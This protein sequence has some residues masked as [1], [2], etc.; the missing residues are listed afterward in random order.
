M[1]LDLKR[2]CENDPS[3]PAAAGVHA[4][5]ANELAATRTALADLKPAAKTER[6]DRSHRWAT[7]SRHR[8]TM[9]QHVA[10]AEWEESCQQL[11]GTN[12]ALDL[13]EWCLLLVNQAADALAAVSVESP[14]SADKHCDVSSHYGGDVDELAMEDLS[15]L[16]ELLLAVLADEFVAVH[17]Q[18]GRAAHQIHACLDEV[19]EALRD[20]PE[21]GH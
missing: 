6:Q 5:L 1:G 19:Q 18:S 14:P 11:L 3:G 12:S 10:A 7:S 8:N 17:W 2:L 16:C 13:R 20:C 4:F 9:P 21:A 15:V